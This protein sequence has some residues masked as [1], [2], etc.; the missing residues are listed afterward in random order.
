MAPYSPKRHILDCLGPQARAYGK[1][2]QRGPGGVPA[3]AASHLRAAGYGPFLFYSPDTAGIESMPQS[4]VDRYLDL[5][6]GA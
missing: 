5:N 4:S 6:N 2:L 1:P 3:Q